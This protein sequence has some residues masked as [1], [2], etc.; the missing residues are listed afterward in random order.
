MHSG[1]F[2]YRRSLIADSSLTSEKREEFNR[3]ITEFE[4]EVHHYF[5]AYIEEAITALWYGA[6]ADAWEVMRDSR[7]TLDRAMLFYNQ[8]LDFEYYVN[9]NHTSQIWETLSILSI[10]IVFVLLA[11]VVITYLFRQL[12]N[13]NTSK[14]PL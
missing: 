3:L 4:T 7:A 9:A 10:V 13:K 14:K 1:C 6:G 12:Q 11:I 5:D 2:Y 8:L